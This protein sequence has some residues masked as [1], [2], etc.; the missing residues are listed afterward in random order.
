ML[1]CVCLE[2]NTQNMYHQI[3]FQI[4]DVEK[5]ETQSLFSVTAV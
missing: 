1:F 3:R 4:D 2:C 5:N